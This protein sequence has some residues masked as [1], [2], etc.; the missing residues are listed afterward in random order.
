MLPPVVVVA[1]AVELPVAEAP[2]FTPEPA[3]AL[4]L[5]LEPLDPDPVALAVALAVGPLAAPCTTNPV[6]VSVSIPD[7]TEPSADATTVQTAMPPLIAQSSESDTL[8]TGSLYTRCASVAPATSVAVHTIR[9][10][11]D[12]T[13][14]IGNQYD[15]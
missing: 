9:R 12:K 15:P 4:A 2:V 7:W 13:A 5:E 1:A 11:F 6:A 10:T 3:V 14:Q 8:A